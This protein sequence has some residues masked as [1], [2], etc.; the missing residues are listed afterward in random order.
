MSAEEI[1]KRFLAFFT[2]RGHAV[3]ASSSL[4]PSDPSVLL[5]TA[6][7]QQFKNYYTGAADAMRDFGSQNV[8]SCQKSFRTSDIDEVGDERHLTFFEMLGN[9]SFGGYGKREAI[10]YAFD[11]ITKEIGAPISFVTVFEGSSVV[12]RDEESA[13]IWKG[14]G[15]TDIRYEGMADVFWGPTGS[16][17]PC[18]PTTEI[19]CKNSVGADV[20]IWNIVFNQFLYDGSREELLAGAAGK[21]LKPLAQFGVDTGMGLERLAMVAQKTKSVFETDVFAPL[22]ALARAGTFDTKQQRIIVDH[23]RGSV[24]LLADGVRPSNKGAGYVA[25]RLLRRVFA[26]MYLHESRADLFEELMK[27][28]IAQY[29]GF[30]PELHENKSEIINAMG[31]EYEQFKKTVGS[32]V[33][34]IARLSK[35]DAVAAFGLYQS[36]GIT[37][38]ITKELGGN[39]ATDLTRADFDKEFE[40]HQAIS[41]AGVE[42]KFGGHGL[43]LDTGELK[44]GNEEELAKVTRLHTATHLLQQALRDV[45]GNGVEQCGSDITG[46]RTRFDF[47][48]SRK[49]TADELR[50]VEETVNAKIKD[51]LPVSFAEMPIAEAKKTGALY[52]FKEK[53][54]DMVKVYFIGARPSAVRASSEYQ[55]NSSRRAY[56]AE[57][58]G[59]PHVTRTGEIGAFKITKEEAIAQGIRRL[60][61]T[62]G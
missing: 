38:E 2:E 50:R 59:G 48:F 12:P 37:Y 57:F 30:Y 3:V 33:K 40:K 60:R 22:V 54:P 19:Y 34:E 26:Y 8:A 31:A 29:G 55:P 47:S 51:D 58:C 17:G 5:T 25:R 41:R 24:F 1:H 21:Q 6:G 49:V 43:L 44:A 9:F 46:E 42:K 11:F 7:M 15:I 10:R 14:L 4:V 23:A 20:E 53:Y 62:V 45:L 56:S 27:M 16:S 13:V 61:A 32:G 28:V 52:Y 39:K 35:I 18:G 36:M